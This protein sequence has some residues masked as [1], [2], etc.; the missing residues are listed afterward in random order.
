MANVGA[1]T[2]NLGVKTRWVWCK[3]PTYSSKSIEKETGKE[4]ALKQAMN[5]T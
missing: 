2:N 1:V 5:L 4:Q 3:L